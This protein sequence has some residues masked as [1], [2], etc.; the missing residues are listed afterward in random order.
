MLKQILYLLF[1][2]CIASCTNTTDTKQTIENSKPITLSYAKRFTIKKEKDY[3]VLELLGNKH[4][5]EVTATFVLY[6]DQKP[7]YHKEAYYVKTPVTRVACMS[8]IYTTMI[9]KLNSLN[10]IVAIDN[11]DYYNNAFI[12]NAV[13]QHKIVELSKGPHIEV[14]KTLALKPDLLL[15][16]GMGNPK[17]DVDIK[18]LQANLPI[19]IS[20]D[21]FEETPLARYEWIKFIS[22]F[23]GK[24]VMADS[25]FS[26]AEKHYNELKALTKNITV[27]PT[28]L[29][30]MKYGDV[31]YVPAGKSF[32]SH[33][34]EDAGADYLWADDDKT[35]SIPLA[36]E[37]VYAKAKDCDVWINMYNIN[38][39][40]E[41][42]SYDERYCL[43]K[44]F[45]DN[46]LYNNN[47]TQN[48]KGYSD[49][50][51]NGISNPDEVLADLI[52]IFHPGLLPDHS[53]KFYK[54]IE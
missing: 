43:F 11:V 34:I 48:S 47:K 54:K 49:Y 23:F 22:C 16:F 53:F 9:E 39:K 3:T 17:N 1:V 42:T 50:W 14:E 19:A 36:F 21:H 4:N 41:L 33:L 18:L 12:Q 2:L 44:A 27:K 25:L 45:K 26:A 6:T 31:W 51:E 7:S 35:G 30:E 52:Y 38:S 24:E 29:T 15:T 13:E 37:N 10:T 40:K 5:T 46:K 32:I 8:S 20:L 28:V